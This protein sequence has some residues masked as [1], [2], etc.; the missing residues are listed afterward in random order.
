MG[1]VERAVHDGD[2]RVLDRRAEARLQQSGRGR[3]NQPVPVGDRLL[4]RLQRIALHNVRIGD[5]FQ[6]VRKHTLDVLSPKLV[7]V[8]PAGLLRRF[9]VQEGGFQHGG[10]R[11]QD[12]GKKSGLLFRLRCELH[13]DGRLLLLQPDLLPHTLD[14]F[15]DLGHRAGGQA[16]IAINLYICQHRVTRSGAQLIS[17]A[18]PVCLIEEV[19]GRAKTAPFLLR[20]FLRRRF[21]QRLLQRLIAS[22]L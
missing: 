18:C 8:S 3:K 2:L 4:D 16:L 7:P 5:G 10:A 19:V 13:L 20:P 12:H 9:V 1:G 14:G 11:R 21:P 15:F 17:A 22:Q 6:A